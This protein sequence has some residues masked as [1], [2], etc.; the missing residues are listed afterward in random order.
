MQIACPNCD[1]SYEVAD[2]ALGAGRNVRCIECRTVWFATAPEQVAAEAEAAAPEPIAEMPPASEPAPEQDDAGA[3]D[4]GAALKERKTGPNAAVAAE[5]E[6]SLEGTGSPSLVPSDDTPYNF[7]HVA[8]ESEEDIEAAAARRSA[9]R[10]KQKKPPALR[11]QRPSWPT[12]I[13]SLLTVV[14]A[15]LGWR[16]DVVRAMPQTA[17]LFAAIGLPVNLRGLVFSDITT[18]KELNE[19]VPVLIVEGVIANVTR[20]RVEVPRL[21]F[22]MRDAH[23]LEIY[24]WTARPTSGS[25]GAGETLLFRTRLA[26]PPAEGREVLVRFA[27]RRDR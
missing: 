23:G 22:A 14:G 21:R 6:P 4:W 24:T 15:I 8:S 13:L 20:G 9:R 25:L 11:L 5:A 16:T 7:D 12:V 17:S 18:T 19:G 3:I 1:T 27:N 2:S 10:R 26:S